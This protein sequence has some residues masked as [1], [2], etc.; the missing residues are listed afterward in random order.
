MTNISL[1]M[2]FWVCYRKRSIKKGF[3]RADDCKEYRLNISAIL[4][5][6]VH[7]S[8]VERMFSTL[9]FFMTKGYF[10]LP[11][12]SQR[13]NSSRRLNI[14]RDFDI[15]QEARLIQLLTSLG[16]NFKMRGTLSLENSTDQPN[17]RSKT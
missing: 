14:A 17:T 11:F 3:N 2:T 12:Y 9:T 4:R 16:S 8:M 15:V 13:F 1:R 6:K 7:L 5:L 10:F